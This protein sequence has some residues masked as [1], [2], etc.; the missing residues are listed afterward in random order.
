MGK[1]ESSSPEKRN[2]AEKTKDNFDQ[3]FPQSEEYWKDYQTLHPLTI[4][5]LLGK[6]LISKDWQR[7]WGDWVESIARRQTRVMFAE[8]PD[9][10]T[11]F[12]LTTLLGK[13]SKLGVSETLLRQNG[14][15][16]PGEVLGGSLECPILVINTEQAIDRWFDQM[17]GNPSAL[18]YDNRGIAF[19]GHVTITGVYDKFTRKPVGLLYSVPGEDED[20]FTPGKTRRVVREQ[21]EKDTALDFGSVLHPLPLGGQRVGNR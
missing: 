1:P 15:V 18:P 19:F 2:I 3:L 20:D 12:A 10:K 4:P 13:P 5:A 14:Y 21:G 17:S 9:D 6:Y 11:Q 8:M 16:Q 7:D